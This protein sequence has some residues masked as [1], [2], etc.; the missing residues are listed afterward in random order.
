MIHSDLLVDTT[1]LAKCF[2]VTEVSIYHWVDDGLPV[3]ST[4][5]K[6]NKKRTFYLPDCFDW[7]TKMQINQAIGPRLDLQ[8][9]TAKKTRVQTQ[10]LELDLQVKQGLLIP[11]GQVEKDFADI[12][13]AVKMKLLNIPSAISQLFDSIVTA[14]N[15]REIVEEQLR[16]ALEDLA[17]QGIDE[18]HKPNTGTT[19]ST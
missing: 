18:S 15:L 7:R 9:E 8:Q 19:P 17:K 16:N 4:E 1:I 6:G 11:V 3:H 12:M 13:T 10:I 5:T 14:D 2:G